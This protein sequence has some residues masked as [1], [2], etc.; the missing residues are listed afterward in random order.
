MLLAVE[1]LSEVMYFDVMGLLGQGSN[2]AVFK[3]GACFFVFVLGLPRLVCLA[4]SLLYPLCVLP[5]SLL[6]CLF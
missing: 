6:A 3:V 5:P 1:K 4:R 2:G